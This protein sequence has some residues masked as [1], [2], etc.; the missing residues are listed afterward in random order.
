MNFYEK[1]LFVDKI[2]EELKNEIVFYGGTVPY[3]IL[4]QQPKARQFSDID[5]YAKPHSLPQLK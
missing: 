1:L 5:M 2:P 3:A 4:G